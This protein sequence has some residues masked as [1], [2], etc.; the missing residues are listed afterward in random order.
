[1]FKK[2]SYTTLV[3]QKNFK[4]NK[5]YYE[6]WGYFIKNNPTSRLLSEM[7]TEFT[8]CI[9]RY[10]SDART[11]VA[12]SEWYE[13]R[14]STSKI[15]KREISLYRVQYNIQYKNCRNNSH[16]FTFIISHKKIFYV[17][18]ENHKIDEN[19]W[20]LIKSKLNFIVYFYLECLKNFI[21]QILP[22]WI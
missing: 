7:L 14:R 17:Q 9:I 10:N 21:H 2:A 16:F 1:V 6:W 8:Y 3:E 12:G 22:R 19:E 13:F 11:R 5:K 20:K 4:K 18:I 15:F